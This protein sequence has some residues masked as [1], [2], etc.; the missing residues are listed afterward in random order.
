MR[1]R[2]HCAQWL[3]YRG[4]L[5]PERRRQQPERPGLLKLLGPAARHLHAPDPGILQHAL[6]QTRLA[7]PGLTL[8]QH[9]RRPT[10]SHSVQDLTQDLK[11]RPAAAQRGHQGHRIQPWRTVRLCGP[12]R[13]SAAARV[14]HHCLRGRVRKVGIQQLLTPPASQVGLPTGKRLALEDLRDLRFARCGHPAGSIVAARS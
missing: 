14:D 4:P 13:A 2:A 3:R 1:A 12:R 10:R 7:D 11:L 6:Q 5:A 9:Q 8:D